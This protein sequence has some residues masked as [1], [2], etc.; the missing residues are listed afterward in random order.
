MLVN[1]T[2]ATAHRVLAGL[3]RASTDSLTQLS[4]ALARVALSNASISAQRQSSRLFRLSPPTALARR[5]YATGGSASKSTGAAKSKATTKKAAPKKKKPAVKAKRPRKKVLTD[6]QKG[7]AEIRD[8]KKAA[9]S[10]PKGLPD[11]AWTVLVAEMS[12]SAHGLQGK[13]A[14]ARYKTFSPEDREVSANGTSVS[15]MANQAGF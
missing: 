4:S 3:P 12:K 14:S 13:E 5:A 8:L 2:R 1:S 7:K 15:S 11:T 9:L 6:E 10:E